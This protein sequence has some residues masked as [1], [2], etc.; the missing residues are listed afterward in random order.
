MWRL[1]GERWREIGLDE[2]IGNNA[3]EEDD[4]AHHALGPSK[5]DLRDQRLHG[6][7]ERRCRQKHI[8]LL[9]SPVALPLPRLR[10]ND[11]WLQRKA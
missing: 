1:S 9:R 2:E 6:V 3:E 4:E 7:A 8:L 11:Q 5:P 10:R